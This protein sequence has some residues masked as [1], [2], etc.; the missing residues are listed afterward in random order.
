[1]ARNAKLNGCLPAAMGFAMI[2]TATSLGA[3]AQAYPVKPI[4]VVVPVGVGGPPDIAGR[5]LMQK[6]SESLGQA[7]VI[8]NRLGAG[9]TIGGQ[10][11][12]K[13]APDGYT[14]M[15]GSGSS[16]V[17]GPTLFPA[18]AYS[19]AKSFAPISLVS[20][21]PFVF[22]VPTS[23]KADTLRDF[24]ALAKANPAKYNYGSTLTG[25]PPNMAGE[26]FKRKTGV[27]L[28][29]IPFG[30][31]AK[32]VTAMVAGDAHLYIEVAPVFL[33]QVS[34]GRIKLL[35]TASAKR[36]PFMPEVP[37]TSEA[38]LPDFEIGS[39]NAVVA[40]AG[41]PG[42]IVMRLN[43]E[44]HKAMASKEL[45]EGFTKAFFEIQ[46]SSPEELGRFMA[47]ELEKWSRLIIDAG[48]KAN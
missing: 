24:I 47:S 3:F 21:Q 35:A 46:L 8:E 17:I 40:P 32:A 18:A 23:L 11:V 36:S 5:M 45:Q 12:V 38:G 39:W 25:S 7:M 27:D 20:H 42:A 48:I 2:V 43:A 22:G 41:M 9:G 37:T 28:V 26:W 4:R 15:M 19:P 33:A 34:A 14:L 16:L 6:M 1:M 13:S 44:V 31:S 29:H 10:V 30:G